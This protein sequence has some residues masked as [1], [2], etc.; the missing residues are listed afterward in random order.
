MLWA[1]GPWAEVSMESRACGMLD[2]PGSLGLGPWS[3]YP[4][5]N[6][7]TG[8][9]ETAL[10]TQALLSPWPVLTEELLT[11]LPAL[12]GPEHPRICAPPRTVVGSFSCQ[13]QDSHWPA[14][15]EALSILFLHLRD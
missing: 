8:I 1:Q 6:T 10:L 7:R 9:R 3:P 11:H 13:P 15:L 12:H 5:G 4:T 2:V 14:Y